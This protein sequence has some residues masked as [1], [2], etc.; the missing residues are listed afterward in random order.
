MNKC[1]VKLLIL[2]LLFY[3]LFL[4]IFILARYKD[5]HLYSIYVYTHY[6]TQG[7]PNTDIDNDTSQTKQS[8]KNY[9]L[10]YELFLAYTVPKNT[11][12]K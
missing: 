6:E 9:N 12:E 2:L 8:V 1:I 10:Q 7:L 4:N 5:L 3:I 11:G